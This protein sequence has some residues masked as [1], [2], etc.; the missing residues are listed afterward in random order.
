M[1][2]QNGLTRTLLVLLVVAT[3]PGVIALG[4][5]SGLGESWRV[6]IADEGFEIDFPRK[7][8]ESAGTETLCGYNA[9]YRRFELSFDGRLWSVT[10]W[11]LSEPLNPHFQRRLIAQMSLPYL[12]ELPPSEYYGKDCAAGRPGCGDLTLLIPTGPELLCRLRFI[13]DGKTVYRLQAA[14]ELR[15]QTVD[16]RDSSDHFAEAC[17]SSFRSDPGWTPN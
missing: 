9:T 1:T 5:D 7:P 3:F 2:L 14:Q 4:A 15:T 11:R 16:L 13:I 17:F 12:Q 8:Y 6:P 10:R